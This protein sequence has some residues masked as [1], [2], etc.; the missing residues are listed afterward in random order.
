[1]TGR[2]L[3]VDGRVVPND[4]LKA[5]L[6][7]LQDMLL[8]LGGDGR[9]PYFYYEPSTGSY[10]EYTEFGATLRRFV[11]TTGSSWTDP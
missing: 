4:D 7:R 6:R 1:M 10:W 11:A 9:M 8:C 3:L 2:S 5:L